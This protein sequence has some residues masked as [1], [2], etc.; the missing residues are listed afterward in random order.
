IEEVK[1]QGVDPSRITVVRRVALKY[2]GTDSPLWVPFGE[3]AQMQAAFADQYRQRYGFSVPGKALIVELV[4]A[5][6][7]GAGE[8][9]RE[10]EHPATPRTKPLEAAAERRIFT[11]GKH[12]TAKFYRR[13]EVRVG[14]RIPGPSVIVEDNATTVVEPGWE[15]EVSTLDHLILT[16]VVPLE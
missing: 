14:D 2:Q 10:Q 13:S 15:A 1:S 5:E 11:G 3:V 7:V 8:P 16:R 12:V 9:I 4:A 6:A